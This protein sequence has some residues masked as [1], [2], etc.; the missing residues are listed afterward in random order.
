[1]I[2]VSRT[3]LANNSLK[4]LVIQ[5]DVVVLFYIPIE[6]VFI[7]TRNIS[8]TESRNLAFLY[9]AVGVKTDSIYKRVLPHLLIQLI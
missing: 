3:T 1:M 6:S 4:D 7:S 5:A 9:E 2:W 8:T